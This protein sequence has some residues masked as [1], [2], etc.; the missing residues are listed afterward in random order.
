M[1]FKSQMFGAAF[2]LVTRFSDPLELLKKKTRRA[3]FPLRELTL[4]ENKEIHRIACP[5]VLRNNIS[6]IPGMMG[7]PLSVHIFT[8][9]FLFI[10]S[11]V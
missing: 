7:K 5:R 3:H 9:S 1:V 2:R 8:T 11:L 6:D 4:E 10:M